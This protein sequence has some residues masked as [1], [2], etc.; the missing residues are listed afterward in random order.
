MEIWKKEGAGT[1][2]GT[3]YEN[4]MS[5]N[6]VFDRIA[7]Y[8]LEEEHETPKLIL[9]SNVVLSENTFNY[10]I[11]ITGRLNEIV[12]NITVGVSVIIKGSGMGENGN[13]CS[14]IKSAG[15][16]IIT[17]NSGCTCTIKNVIIDGSDSNGNKTYQGILNNGSLTLENCE[18]R[19][20]YGEG[21]WHE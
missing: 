13:Q 20:C 14:T 19:N 6:N 9:V 18:I 12:S 16:K 21:Y 1:E 3:S 8:L 15:G 7:E 11:D 10:S 5:I 4:R 2:D 17:I